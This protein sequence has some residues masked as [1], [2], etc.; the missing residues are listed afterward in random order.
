MGK[1]INLEASD[2]PCMFQFFKK[3]VHQT[4]KNEFYC[5]GGY[6]RM[7]SPGVK[8]DFRSVDHTYEVFALLGNYWGGWNS[9]PTACEMYDIAKKWDER[10]CAEITGLSY[11]SIDFLFNRKLSDIEIETLLD[12]CENIH[13]DVACSGGYEEMRKIIKEKSELH[14][15]WD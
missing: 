8:V 5:D 3:F 9:T 15:W 6:V 11:N 14:I 7:D 4:E 10:F 13:A 1:K 2:D 12:E